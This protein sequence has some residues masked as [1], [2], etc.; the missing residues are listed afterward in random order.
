[1]PDQSINT[2]RQLLWQQDK[3]EQSFLPSYCRYVS[4]L[5]TDLFSF[6]PER[7]QPAQTIAVTAKMQESLFI[8]T[9]SNTKK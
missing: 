2:E 5:Y 8:K 3:T 7:H 9:N 1:M 6:M 4:P